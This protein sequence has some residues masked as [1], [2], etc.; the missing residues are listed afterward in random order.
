MKRLFV[1]L[2]LFCA[3]RTS[4]IYRFD[5]SHYCIYGRDSSYTLWWVEDT[6]IP[7]PYTGELWVSPWNKELHFAGPNEHTTF[8][9]IEEAEKAAHRHWKQVVQSWKDNK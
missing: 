4:K 3:C 5:E 9:T 6:K 8:K 2:L 1:L 7:E